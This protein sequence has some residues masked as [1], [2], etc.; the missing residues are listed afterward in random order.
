M[1]STNFVRVGIAA[2]RGFDYFDDACR[3]L[4][5][6]FV[7]RFA[8][9]FDQRGKINPRAD[10]VGNRVQIGPEAIGGDLEAPDLARLSL[11][12]NAMVSSGVRLPT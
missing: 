11:F 12:A 3:G 5:R 4:T 9:D 6:P 10:D 2:L 1:R 7:F 8:I